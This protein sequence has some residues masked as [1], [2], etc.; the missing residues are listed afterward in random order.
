[1]HLHLFPEFLSFVS[2]AM[3]QNLRRAHPPLFSGSTKSRS[4]ITSSRGC[5][6]ARAAT[7]LSRSDS[8]IMKW[9]HYQD[10]KYNAMIWGRLF[11]NRWGRWDL[12]FKTSICCC[13]I[14]RKIGSSG[15][16]AVGVRFRSQ[17]LPRNFL[18]YYS[19][20]NHNHIA[21]AAK[22]TEC[23]CRDKVG[24]FAHLRFH[25]H[26]DNLNVVLITNA[27]HFCKAKTISNG[28]YHFCPYAY[29]KNRG[30]SFLLQW[31]WSLPMVL[32]L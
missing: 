14:S 17:S 27:Y 21:L 25:R 24:V 15:Q 16:T 31:L 10:R 28:A 32:R 11:T 9:L 12:D 18:C 23:P 1:M 22:S 8:F 4:Q 5:R 29:D 2:N 20:L 26:E 19:F 7:M 3:A 6:T 13:Y 30:L